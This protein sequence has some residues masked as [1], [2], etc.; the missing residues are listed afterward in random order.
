MNPL[1]KQFKIRLNLVKRFTT[2]F[3]PK[4]TLSK[5]VAKDFTGNLVSAILQTVT[6]Y[7]STIY[8]T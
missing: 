6:K 3:Q 4:T 8:P 2:G 7:N 5:E 1:L